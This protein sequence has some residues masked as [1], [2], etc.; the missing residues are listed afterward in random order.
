[1][2]FYSIAEVAE[3]C[4][5][6]QKTIRRQVAS[7]LLKAKRLGNQWRIEDEDFSRW[8]NSDFQTFP[9]KNDLDEQL[10][11]FG[12]EKIIKS[13]RNIK[14]KVDKVNWID[15]SEGWNKKKFEKIFNYIDLFSGAGGISLGFEL[16]GF[17]GIAAVEIMPAAIETY[18][19]NFRY[20]V[21]PDD[22]R[23]EETKQKLYDIVEMFKEK[24][25]IM[26]VD[27]ICGGFPCQG[28]SMSGYRIVDDS[29][30]DLYREML[31]IVKRIKPKFVL[32]ENVIGLRSM[33]KGKIEEK[34]INDYEGIGYD[35]NVTVLNSA[36]YY[37]P[38]IRKRVIFIGNRIGKIN[39]H[40]RPL[41]DEEDYLS[42][43]DAIED[44]INHPVDPEFN[45]VPTIHTKAMK[46]RLKAVREGGSLYENYSDSWKKCP[47]DEP[48]CTI[49]ENHGGVNIHPILPRVLTAREMARLQSF[50][51]DFIFKGSKKWQLVQI[52]NAVPP[53]LAKA[54]ALGIRKTLSGD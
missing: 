18:A 47:W 34:I 38:Q 2:K 39:Y 35:I 32:L 42:T 17:E 54:I 26:D 4:K 10:T 44:L 52:G 23:K 29:R 20:P 49:K 11:L 12:Q 28:F 15:I 25:N 9:V 7:G 43:K 8:L 14:S 27:V 46:A 30:N 37:T 3:L 22:I 31:N 16:A 24:N 6:S 51:D 21:V 48:S 1:M 33:L 36:D 5:L 41:L 50:P 19:Y 45:H 40:P 53:L 13:E